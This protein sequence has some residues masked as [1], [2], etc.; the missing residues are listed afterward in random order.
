[1]LSNVDPPPSL[2]P[3]ALPMVTQQEA[4]P[5]GRDTP[6][7]A[8]H[9]SALR[10]HWEMEASRNRW[11]GEGRVREWGVGLGELSVC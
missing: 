1:M 7:L 4:D 11:G 6:P 9:V 5:E 2:F 8:G 10:D 3:S